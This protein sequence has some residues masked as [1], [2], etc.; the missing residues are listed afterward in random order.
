MSPRALQDFKQDRVRSRRLPDWLKMG[1]A[2]GHEAPRTNALMKELGLHTICESGR[3]PNRNECYSQKTATFMIM[4]DV[5]TRSCY[6]CSPKSQ[7]RDFKFKTR[8]CDFG[9]P[10]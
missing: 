9:E 6:F 1:L 10:G 2:A 8:C 4:G 5:C 7:Q 3:C